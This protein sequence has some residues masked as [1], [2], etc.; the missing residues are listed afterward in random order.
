MFHSRNG[1]ISRIICLS[2]YAYT[3]GNI[4]KFFFLTDEAFH[5]KK[6]KIGNHHYRLIVT[7]L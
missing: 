7:K 1:S 6:K 2:K 3:G 4:F 5:P